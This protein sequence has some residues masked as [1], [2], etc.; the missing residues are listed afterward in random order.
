[1]KARVM[2]SKLSNSIWLRVEG[3]GEPRQDADAVKIAEILLTAEQEEI[4]FPTV[5]ITLTEV[6]A[7]SVLKA[8]S[9]SNLSWDGASAQNKLQTAIVRAKEERK[10]GEKR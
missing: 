9:N 1:M 10:W 2:K 3:L 6:E 5:T 8:L 4:L 7:Q